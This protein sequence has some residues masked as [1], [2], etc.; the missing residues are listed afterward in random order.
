MATFSGTC[1]TSCNF[2]V[3]IQDNGEPGN[4]MDRFSISVNGGPAEGGLITKGNTQVH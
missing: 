2:T 3:N 1:G 4:G